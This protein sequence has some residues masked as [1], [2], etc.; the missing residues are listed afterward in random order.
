MVFLHE[1]GLSRPQV[2]ALLYIYH[3]GECQISEIGSL[4]G[5]SAPAASQLVDRLVQQGWVE[6]S[7]DPQNRRV[8]KLRLTEKSLKLISQGVAS[9]HFLREL[10]ARL[11]ANQRETVRAALGYLAEAGEQIHASHVRK[12]KHHAP[13][14]K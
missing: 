4:T 9:N 1:T 12:V 2:H 7:E 10:M 6:R 3:A 13:H 14:A 8:K 11:T 5:S